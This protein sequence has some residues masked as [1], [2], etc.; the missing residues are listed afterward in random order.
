MPIYKD[1]D[2]PLPHLLCRLR[3]RARRLCNNC[4]V[5]PA[6]NEKP[7][8]HL[9]NDH[10]A[11]EQVRSFVKSWAKNRGCHDRLICNF[12]QVWTTLHRPQKKCLQRKAAQR[13]GDL[14]KTAYMRR[15]RHNVQR[16]LGIDFTEDD[17][18]LQQRSQ[19]HA[20][21][22]QGSAQAG[23]TVDNWRSPR[24]LTT[25]SFIDGYVGRGYVTC[26]TGTISQQTRAWA[27]EKL[28][29][30]LYVAEPQEGTHIW[31]EASLI[32]YLDFL[33]GEIRKRRAELGLSGKQRALVILDQ[34]GAHMSRTYESLQKKWCE[35]NNVAAG[36]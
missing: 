31:N 24:T 21:R 8:A 14:E 19:P 25:L 27:N 1:I 36:P 17:P 12:D 11:L 34:A 22:V 4:G 30:W 7:G 20:P 9:E 2:E 32:P 6:T 28:G 3:K 10:P 18:K 13:N 23:A 15:I 16:V 26:K 5:R 29:R 33:A 35:A